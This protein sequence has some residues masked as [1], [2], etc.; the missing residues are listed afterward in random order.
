MEQLKSSYPWD[1]S[2]EHMYN[3]DATVTSIRNLDLQ[4]FKVQ[5]TGLQQIENFVLVLFC[6]PDP[7]DEAITHFVRCSGSWNRWN[8]AYY[9]TMTELQ[10][11]CDTDFCFVIIQGHNSQNMS[12]EVPESSSARGQGKY[13]YCVVKFSLKSTR[14][15]ILNPLWEMYAI[16]WSGNPTLKSQGDRCRWLWF[17]Y[18][19]AKWQN[20]FDPEIKKMKVKECYFPLFVYIAALQKEKEHVQGFGAEEGELV[21]LRD[22]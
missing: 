9:W 22:T 3:K 10:K 20:F 16:G 19:T 1:A 17:D 5:L 21:S 12:K 18:V 13:S 8:C 14:D 2:K 6:K 4:L 11:L 15:S 7:K